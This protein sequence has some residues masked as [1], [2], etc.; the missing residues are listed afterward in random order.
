MLLSDVPRSVRMTVCRITLDLI[1]LCVFIPKWR[2]LGWAAL[3][4]HILPGILF[5]YKHLHDTSDLFVHCSFC[6]NTVISSL[7]L[8]YVINPVIW[9]TLDTTF[10]CGEFPFL[11][12]LSAL[13]SIPFYNSSKEHAMKMQILV[14]C[15]LLTCW[16]S[17]RLWEWPN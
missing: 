2:W 7:Q 1:G 17:P 15:D 12:Q 8:W 3:P 5:L 6:C 14:S 4:G 13:I 11:W 10:W 16:R 9:F